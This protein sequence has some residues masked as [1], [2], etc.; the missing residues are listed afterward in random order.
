[1]PTKKVLITGGGGLLGASL[2]RYYIERGYRVS[3]LL[4]HA[5]ELWR[6]QNILTSVT[7]YS[8]DI[9]DL[10]AVKSVFLQV[11]PHIVLHCAG[12]GRASF[13]ADKD[14]IYDI[15]FQG[16]MHV[17]QA[18]KEVGFE[19]FINTGSWQ[20]YGIYENTVTE[21]SMLSPVTDF[22]VSKA[23]AT[24]YCLK[25]AFERDLPIYTVRP[26]FIYGN[27]D[28]YTRLITSLLLGGIK[29]E[30]ICVSSPQRHY[31]FIHVFDVVDLYA[32][33]ERIRP[34]NQFIF[35]AATGNNHSIEE[36]VSTIYTLFDQKFEYCWGQKKAEQDLYIQCF[37]TIEHIKKSF[38]WEPNYSLKEGLIAYKEWLEQNLYLHNALIDNRATEKISMI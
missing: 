38:G 2:A 28:L 8:A 12:Y 24:Q 7:L 6:I 18:A 11:K 27:Y 5:P 4:E 33:I 31:D 19:C 34:H 17:L 23:A 21:K 22:G 1:M 30:K 3:L 37:T 29:K 26:F 16:T 35:N 9:R 36:L 10:A 32:T 20:E 25:E 13:Q 15:N 14:R